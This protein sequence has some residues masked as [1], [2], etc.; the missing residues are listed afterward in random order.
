MF[1][2]V[3]KC[4][5]YLVLEKESNEWLEHGV[6]LRIIRP[7]LLHTHTQGCTV[8][9]VC[10]L[11]LTLGVEEENSKQ[12]IRERRHLT[13]TCHN[14]SITHGNRSQISRMTKRA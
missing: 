3:L 2:S 5:D 6:K 12:P 10:D 1:Q 7:S 4:H 14:V 9:C 11:R 8:D 13:P